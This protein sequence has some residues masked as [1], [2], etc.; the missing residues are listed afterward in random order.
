LQSGRHACMH[1]RALTKMG[2]MSLRGL[3]RFI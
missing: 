2:R 3:Y 1:E